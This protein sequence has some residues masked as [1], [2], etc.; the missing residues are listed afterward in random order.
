M[1]TLLEIQRAISRAVV[2]RETG[3]AA[4]HIVCDGFTA[5]ERLNVYRNTFLAGLT[6]ALRL[7]HPAVH[8]LVG[9]EFFDGAAQCFVEAAPPQSAYLNSYGA[10]FADFL[11]TFPPAAS[12]AYLADVARLEWAVNTALHAPD[13]EPLG[14]EDFA[15]IADVPPERLVLVPHPSIG[16]LR[17]DHPADAIWRAVLAQDDAAL[18]SIDPTA[19]PVWLMVVRSA[20]GVEVSPLDPPDWRFTASLC[21]GQSFAEAVLAAAGADVTPV[22]AQHLAA[23]RFTQFRLTADSQSAFSGNAP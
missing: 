11:A 17:L 16:L 13:V 10:G 7:A 1:P 9:E 20:Q 5:E 23:G 18:S 8:R 19:G 15:A 14:A 12:L 3:D 4:P 6:T 22:L 2:S 21:A